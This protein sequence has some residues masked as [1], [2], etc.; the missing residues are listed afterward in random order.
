MHVRVVEFSLYASCWMDTCV[1]GGLASDWDTL[2]IVATTTETS[3]WLSICYKI[4]F[5][6]VHSS[7]YFT[8]QFNARVWNI[9]NLKTSSNVSRQ[10]SVP[11]GYDAGAVGNPIKTWRGKLLSLSSKVDMSQ[12]SQYL[13]RLLFSFRHNYTF[14]AMLWFYK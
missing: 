2:K 1:V 9:L 13:P 5:T 6:K 12:N 4:H 7:V 14:T 11:V 3:W 8:L 10:N